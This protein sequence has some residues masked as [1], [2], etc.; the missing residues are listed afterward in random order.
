MQ[1]AKKRRLLLLL[2]RNSRVLCRHQ[3][4]GVD[5]GCVQEELPT[6][7]RRT[8]ILQ[9]VRQVGAELRSGI[10]PKVHFGQL[11]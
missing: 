5:L 2:P 11:F 4:S 6:P 7:R 1:E 8:C 10:V 9:N 3:H